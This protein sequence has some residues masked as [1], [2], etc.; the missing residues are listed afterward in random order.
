MQ[1]QDIASDSFSYR[2]VQYLPLDDS[3]R[4]MNPF[5]TLMST[6][7]IFLLSSHLLVCPF[8]SGS[9]NNILLNYFVISFTHAT[10][11]NWSGHNSRTYGLCSS[12]RDSVITSY[13]R[14]QS[15]VLAATEH[16]PWFEQTATS[17]YQ[18]WAVLTKWRHS[19]LERASA[20]DLSP[21]KNIYLISFQF[22]HSIVSL[23]FFVTFLTFYY[24]LPLPAFHL[25]SSVLFHSITDTLFS[26]VSFCHRFKNTLN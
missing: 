20:L 4:Q 26:F 10:H 25:S 11:P 23:S 16:R 5:G 9:L 2:A 1:D 7:S 3:L 15:R 24:F 19:G 21:A 22:L 13:Q 8:S 17:K 12:Q 18:L 6:Y 14:D